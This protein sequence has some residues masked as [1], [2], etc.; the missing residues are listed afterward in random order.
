MPDLWSAL[1]LPMVTRGSPSGWIMLGNRRDGHPFTIDDERLAFAAA[2]QVRAEYD[3]L[4]GEQRMKEELRA[5]RQDLAALFAASPVPIIS[6]DAGLIVRAW[7]AAAE[8]TF[9]WRAEEVI[10]RPSPAIPSDLAAQFEAL[11]ARSLA[12]ETLHDV[13]V[14]R[15]RKDGS[16]IDVSSSLAPLRGADGQ[17]NGFVSIAADITD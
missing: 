3:S 8:R 1:Y 4:R 16:R 6:L 17:T 10:G 7:N 2:A 15:L 14:Q 9:G 11:A 5:S 12:G 13:E